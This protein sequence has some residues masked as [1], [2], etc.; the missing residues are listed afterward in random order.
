M[1]RRGLGRRHA[2]LKSIIAAQTNIRASAKIWTTAHTT[3]TKNLTKWS[4]QE[5]DVLQTAFSGVSNLQSNWANAI[6]SYTDQLKAHRTLFVDILNE[7]KALDVA[8]KS[9]RTAQRKTRKHDKAVEGLQKKGKNT[10]SAQLQLRQVTSIQEICAAEVES[11]LA[12]TTE[13]KTRLAKRALL[14][15]ANAYIALCQKGLALFQAQKQLA[16]ALPDEPSEKQAA[17]AFR[18]RSIAIVKKAASDC[19]A[20]LTTE[21]GIVQD[22]RCGDEKENQ[23]VISMVL[24][25]ESPVHRAEGTSTHRPSPSHAPSPRVPARKRSATVCAYPQPRVRRA[26]KSTAILQS[27][28]G[29]DSILEP[30]ASQCDMS[31]NTDISSFDEPDH[32][33]LWVSGAAT[34]HQ[35]SIAALQSPTGCSAGQSPR[36]NEYVNID[37]APPS[38]NASPT[39]VNGW[40]SS[41][42]SDRAHEYMNVGHV[43][44]R[45]V[46]GAMESVCDTSCGDA[47]DSSVVADDEDGRSP[48]KSA[49]IDTHTPAADAVRASPAV[50]T[51]TRKS[52]IY[53]NLSDNVAAPTAASRRSKPSRTESIGSVEFGFS[54]SSP[55]ATNGKQGTEKILPLATDSP[56]FGFSPG[57]QPVPRVT[58]NPSS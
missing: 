35:A 22:Y 1:G 3:A 52:Q 28:E 13:A 44:L 6:T 37:G 19:D 58:A 26:R 11:T 53:E 36:A 9:L 38:S 12:A 56:V 42:N 39:V 14:D 29:D 5:N 54:T 24:Q 40:C 4:A 25:K 15:G 50:T 45:P 10:A 47:Y 21:S 27:V 41:S 7:E 8:K 23:P 2:G 18:E 48:Q 32:S 30:N 17:A 20:I 55:V 57:I 49:D 33:L 51:R 16:E 43:S 31:F 46:Q 34:T